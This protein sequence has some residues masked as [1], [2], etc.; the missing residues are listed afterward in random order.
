M[1]ATIYSIHLSLLE[2]RQAEHLCKI[3][4]F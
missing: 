2:N 4:S 1:H 3:I